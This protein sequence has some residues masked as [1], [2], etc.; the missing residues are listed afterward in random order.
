MRKIYII[1]AAVLLFTGCKPNVNVSKTPTSGSVDFSNY[2]A[3][4]NSLTSGY[5]DGSLTV[6][7]QLNSYPQRLW[8]QFALIPGANGAKGP[9][10][11]P[12][13]HSDNGYPGP[14]KVLAMTYSSCDPADSSMGPV[15]YQGFVAD[16]VDAQPFSSGINNGQVN[17]IGVPGIRVADYPVLQ[18]SSPNINPYAARFYHNTSG[19]PMDELLY[20]VN[21]YHP[22]FFT[23]WLGANDALGYA[24]AG[25]QGNG[26]LTGPNVALPVALNIFSTSDITPLPVFQKLYD[27]IVSTITHT[28]ASGALI[29]IPDI[30]SLPFFTTIPANG[31]ILTR[32]GQADSL[33]ALY[34]L[35][36]VVFQVGANYFMIQDNAGKTRQAVPGELILL[37][38]PQDQL[39]CNGWGATAPIPSKYVLTTDELQ[40]I[41]AAV[42]NYNAFI[43]QEA[44][45]HNLTYVDMNKYLTAVASGIGYNGINYSAQFVSGGAFSLDGIH[46]TERG[47]ALIANQI[48]SAINAHYHSTIPMV[49]AN[50]YH[51]INFPQ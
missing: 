48:I 26:N 30:T 10:I 14:K 20:R 49:D 32:Q 42:I 28:S 25:G 44:N 19:T 34:P 15:D 8:E 22:T 17:N 9:F 1:G 11:H 39:K 3:V 47:Y 35:L 12:L 6:S 4:G 45:L 7:G 50:K 38:T 2:L 51:G 24:L 21:I 37:T 41:R 5:M 18:Y 27:S 31:L 46:P 23:L 43:Q 16:P 29:N 13:L 33:Q 40:N 36:K